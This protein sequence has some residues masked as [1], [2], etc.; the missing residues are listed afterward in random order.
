MNM[1]TRPL[2]VTLPLR[3]SFPAG[4]QPPPNRIGDDAFLWLDGFLDTTTGGPRDLSRPDV[5]RLIVDALETGVEL[6]HYVL[7]AWAVLANH[8][9]VLLTPRT[10]PS[11]FLL[12]L[13]TVTTR[14]ANRLLERTGVPFWQPQTYH[15]RVRNDAEFERVRTYIE[16]DPVRAGLA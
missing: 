4:L 14:E 8:V 13:K 10:E 15:H 12:A 7:H 9:H 16:S 2:F 11:S 6:G 3:G 1:G 5:A